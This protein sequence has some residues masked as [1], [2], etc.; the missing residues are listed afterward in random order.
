MTRRRSWMVTAAGIVTIV[1][2]GLVIRNQVKVYRNRVKGYEE[3]LARE[4]VIQRRQ[5]LYDMLQPVAL[6]NCRL[7]RFGETHD[8]G[9]LICANLLGAVPSGYSYRISRHH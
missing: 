3:S 7:E 1:I 6:S 5:T 2:V 8:G 4:A 9:Y